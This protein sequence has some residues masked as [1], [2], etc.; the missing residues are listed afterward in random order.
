[1]A[2]DRRNR[3]VLAGLAL[4]LAVV[5]ARAWMAAPSSEP[6][7]G[8]RP[9]AARREAAPGTA[10]EA[11]D[12]RLEAL[13][14]EKPHPTDAKRNLFRFGAIARA[15]VPDQVAP[16]RSFEMPPPPPMPTAPSTPPITLKF[17]GIVEAPEKSQRW[18]VLSDNRGVYQGREGDTIEGRYRI[19]KIGTES[20]ELAYLDGNGRQTIRLSGS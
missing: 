3:L 12:V 7:A 15:S 6:A 1:M 16:N 2:S 9:A 11:P 18:A 13:E 4:I 14:A 20:I 8:S 19:L 5:L 17:I 10:A